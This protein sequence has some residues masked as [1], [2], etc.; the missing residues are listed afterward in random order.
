MGDFLETLVRMSMSGALI[1]VVIMLLRIPLCKAPRKYSYMLWG[2]LGV[3]LLFPFSL[4]SPASLFNLFRSSDGSSGTEV[5]TNRITAPFVEYREIQAGQSQQAV[6]TTQSITLTQVLFWV[7]AAGAVIFAVYMLATYIRLRRR[8]AGA[9]RISDNIYEC[10][11]IPTAFVMGMIR[12]RIYLPAGLGSQDKDFITAH[13][14]THIRRRD[15]IIKPLAV[16]ALCVHW[17][18]P[19]VWV[20]FFLMVRDMEISCDE[21]AVSGLDVQ[22]RKEY[23]N[24]LLNMSA[25]QNRLTGVLAFGESSIKQRIKSILSPRKPTLWISIAAVAVIVI[26]AV[27][28]LTDARKSPESSTPEP[29]ESQ[30]SSQ[31]E[32]TDPTVE[33]SSEPETSVPQQTVPV[34]DAAE[35]I[36]A[37]ELVKPPLLTEENAAATVQKILGSFQLTEESGNLCI[38]FDMPDYIPESSDGKTQLYIS[39]G[40][41]YYL[42]GGT[43]S[44]DRLLDNK[45]MEPNGSYSTVIVPDGK[46]FLGSMLRAA[47]MTDIGDNAYR[48]FYADYVELSP[49][50]IGAGPVSPKKAEVDG[51]TIRYTFSGD[52]WVVRFNEFPADMT[53]EVESG[54][55]IPGIPLI[56]IKKNGEIVGNLGFYSFG[57]TQSDELAQV[58]PMGEEFPMQIYSQIGLSNQIDYSHGYHA[59]SGNETG[60][61]AVAEPVY[62]DGTQVCQ[63]IYAFD[64]SVV[65]YFLMLSLQPGTVTDEELTSM[66]RELTLS[67]N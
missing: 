12:P 13:E 57:T 36:E 53:L 58:D 24:A 22:S 65:P 49:S 20:S 51:A 29:A 64:R 55:V 34:S 19:L 6:Q 17:F 60:S 21:R 40:A 67:I 59:V 62:G 4:P 66:A 9:V 23:A 63:C 43:Y 50:D 42:G 47:F 30:V 38:S 7:W 44:H 18:N 15:N 35:S 48:T 41:D 52:N 32:Q 10:N 61:S 39:L 14:R 2:I 46:E 8:V 31:E 1:S 45:I 33:T 26:A 28:L 56:N 27:C 11:G 16:L 54:E 25:K 5:I 37:P 3:R